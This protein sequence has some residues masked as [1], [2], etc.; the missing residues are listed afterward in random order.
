MIE[1]EI[2]STAGFCPG[3]IRTIGSAES[4][5]REHPGSSLYSLG[6]IVHNDSELERLG[7]MGL[8]QLDTEDLDEMPSA[9]GKTILVRAHGQPPKIF[10]TL[11]RLGFEIIDCTCPVVLG[12]QKKIKEAKGDVIIYG[13]HG[14]PEVLGLVGQAK[15]R[16]RVV[17]DQLQAAQM[18]EN[19]R[20]SEDCE[21]FSQTTMS[22]T[23]Y[24]G[25]CELLKSSLPSLKVHRTICKQVANRHRDLEDFARHHDVIVFVSGKSSSNGRVLCELC[26]QVN[27]RTYHVG[28]V[29]EIQAGWFRP[30]D[31]VGISGATSTPRWLLEEVAA[32]I[33]GLQ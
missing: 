13:K 1:V 31:R 6:A 33:A 32:H 29:Q 12:I 20:P 14:H 19:D 25:V 21:I 23:G 24:A 8:V 5:L 18:L 30:E 22:P 10:D 15:S 11:H 2:D 16:V 26:R 17:E 3:V 4:F 7:A 28:S 27:I 9:E